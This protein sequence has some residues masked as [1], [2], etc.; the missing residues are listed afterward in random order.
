VTIHPRQ[1]SK[2]NNTATPLSV[3]IHCP[4]NAV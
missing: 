2:L 1:T 3:R 4:I